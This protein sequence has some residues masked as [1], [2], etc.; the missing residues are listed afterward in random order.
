MIL[1]TRA[2]LLYTYTHVYSII[3]LDV[4]LVKRIPCSVS[5]LFSKTRVF[6]GRYR[7][8]REF[9]IMQRKKKL[10]TCCVFFSL[11]NYVI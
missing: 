1:L 11:Y 8:M 7:E 9:V 4:C 10:D 5:T 2:C 3:F 6:I